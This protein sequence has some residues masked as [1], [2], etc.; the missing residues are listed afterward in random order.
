MKNV[1]KLQAIVEAKCPR[2]RQGDI[3]EYS[4]WHLTR[5]TATHELCPVCKLR[6]EVEPGFFIGAMY[7]SYAMS[8]ALAFTSGV[9]VYVLGDDPA[10]WVYLV[11]VTGLV[12]LLLPLMFRYSRVLFLYMFSGVKYNKQASRHP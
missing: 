8:V 3:F 10:L 6:Y 5:F 7:I 1:S 12:T 9:A 11:I 4:N 2:C